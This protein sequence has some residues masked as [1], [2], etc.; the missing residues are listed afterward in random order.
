[1]IGF[2]FFISFPWMYA[3]SFV[4]LI[5]ALPFWFSAYP[6]IFYPLLVINTAIFIAVTYFTHSRELSFWRGL[7]FLCGS[8]MSGC[9]NLTIFYIFFI[10]AFYYIRA[11]IATFD[12][13]RKGRVYSQN[14]WID[15]VLSR[16]KSGGW[17]FFNSTNN[18]NSN[19]SSNHIYHVDANAGGDLSLDFPIGFYDAIFGCTKDVRFQHLELGNNGNLNPVTKSISVTIPAG[20]KSGTRLRIA[21]EGDAV[22][23]GKGDLYIVVSAPSQEA[24]FKREGMNIFSDVRISQ[25]QATLGGQIVVNTI[26]GK[27]NLTIPPNT[28]NGCCLTLTGRGVPRL[29]SPTHRGDHII[30]IVL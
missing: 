1:M 5:L 12:G 30:R 8:F 26:D 7:R 19:N 16:A 17:N 18:S 15:T 24:E 25:Q 11:I 3:L 9:A 23:K 14:W 29:G 6:A 21:G 20:I 10:L 4:I 22:D 27:A 28:D 13:V 2:F